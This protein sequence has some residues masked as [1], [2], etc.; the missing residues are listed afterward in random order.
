MMLDKMKG[1]KGDEFICTGIIPV[2][3]IHF[4]ED[5]ILSGSSHG[6][7]L[8]AEIVTHDPFDGP[9]TAFPAL[10]RESH[11]TPRVPVTN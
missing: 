8:N 3:P 11:R 6:T 5:S 7:S 10:G 9:M 4:S 2:S 1:R